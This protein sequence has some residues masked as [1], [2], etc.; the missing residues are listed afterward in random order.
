MSHQDIVTKIPSGFKRIASTQN[1]KF[2]IISNEKRKLYGVQ[3][4]PEVT[5]TENGKILL[6]NFVL[7]ICHTKK[8][9]SLRKQ[10]DLIINDIKNKVKNEKVICAL[11]G[12]V[13]SSVVAFLLN[14]AIGKKLKCVFINTCLLYTSPSPRD[15]E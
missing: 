10:K 15:P 1:S 14:K 9:W 12:G 2:A 13:D 8:M 5:H 7:N 11:S 6:S 3:F 4:H